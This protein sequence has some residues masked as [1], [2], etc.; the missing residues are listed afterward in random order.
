MEDMLTF[1]FET[2][3]TIRKA[4][5]ADWT[6]IWANCLCLWVQFLPEFYASLMVLMIVH[7]SDNSI[8]GRQRLFTNCARVCTC[9]WLANRTDRLVIFLLRFVPI[10]VACFMERMLAFAIKS[11]LCSFCQSLMADWAAFRTFVPRIRI[12]ILPFLQA[13]YVI[14]VVTFQS[15]GRSILWL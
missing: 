9:N 6:K 5:M 8:F 15:C 1:D 10:A 3:H 7:G 13:S 2:F 11:N 4:L 14:A 12:L